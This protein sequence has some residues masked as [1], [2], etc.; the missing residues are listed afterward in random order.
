MTTISDVSEVVEVAQ[1]LEAARK[2][3]VVRLVLRDGEEFVLS[4]VM[5]SPLDVPPVRPLKP[6]TRDEIVAIVREGREREP[7]WLTA[8]FER[9]EKAKR[10]A[11]ADEIDAS[12]LPKPQD[13][14][15]T[16]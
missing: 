2:G 6:I 14:D 12:E 10:N 3:G 9:I 1:L 15:P 4:R 13:G 7:E 5:R 11:P 16:S 8:M